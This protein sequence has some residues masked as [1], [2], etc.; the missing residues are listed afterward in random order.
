MNFFDIILIEKLAEHIIHHKSTIV[1]QLCM[2]KEFHNVTELLIKGTD[3]HNHGQKTVR[4]RLDN[5]SE[6]KQY[7]MIEGDSYEFS[8]YL[9]RQECVDCKEAA[10]YFQRMGIHLFLCY[11]LHAGDMHFENIIALRAFPMLIDVETIPGICAPIE[12]CS[13]EDKIKAILGE[14]V[15]KTGILPVPI[16]KNDEK[17]VIL[18]A[19]CVEGD[20]RSSVH[21]PVIRN[22]KT[23][24]MYVEYKYVSIS[25]KS[26][27]PVISGKAVNPI[28]YTD[29][30]CK[31][32]AG[33][34]KLYTQKKKNSRFVDLPII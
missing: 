11:L 10:Q 26:S 7:A 16:W 13:A 21:L 22:G 25:H 6:E 19:L 3:S 23:S 9:E 28:Q 1:N 2:G 29:E 18:S 5:A 4:C 32:F 12:V 24:E 15:L 30:L 33:A 8:E 34:Y 14:S 17:G 27:I 20:R 31:G